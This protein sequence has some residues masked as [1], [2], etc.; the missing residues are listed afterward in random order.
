MNTGNQELIRELNRQLV[1]KTIIQY[2]PLSRADLAKKC[3]LTKATISS[4]VQELLDKKLIEEIGSGDTSVGRKPILLRFHQTC[5]YVISIDI[6][7]HSFTVLVS[8]LK[9]ENCSLKEYKREGFQV[10]LE[11][12]KKVIDWTIRGIPPCPY[13]V[14]GICLGVYG[15]VKDKEVLFTP[16]YYLEKKKTFCAS[17]EEALHIP[18]FIEN[19]ANLC[20]L[21][22]SAY[23]YEYKNM[24]Y[25]N[26][27]SGIGSGILI[28]GNVFKGKNGYAGEIGHT[29][30]YPNGRPCTCG[31]RGCLEQ[32]ASET[33]LLGDYAKSKNLSFVTIEKFIRDFNE[34]DPLAK[35]IIENFIT[36]MSICINNLILNYN[37]ELIILNSSFTNYI[38]GIAG[39]LQQQIES[40]NQDSVILATAEIQ[41]LSELLGGVT[42]CVNHF[43]DTH[44]QNI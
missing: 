1:L 30:L 42:I 9:G 40:I 20:V 35:K 22:E 13:G 8:D 2:S 6:G 33:A 23:Y 5:G 15:V 10:S 34:G 21:G 14:V 39:Q 38:P 19:D 18:V 11:E 24:I 7:V 27:H 16:H 12:T 36:Y 28:D 17:L 26:V 29:T 37:P 3:G 25:I 4:I 43:I 32:Y 44:S 31:N 41:D